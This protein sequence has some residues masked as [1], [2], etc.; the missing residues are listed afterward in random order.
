MNWVKS[1]PDS[2][3]DWTVE[4]RRPRIAVGQRLAGREHQLGVGHAEDLEHVVEL[5]LGAAVGHELLERPERVA[6]AAGGRARQH[7]HRRVGDLDPLL[8]RHPLASRRRSARATG[9]G[10]RSGGSGR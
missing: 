1:R 6:E 10:S 2:D 7:A 8:G 5:H 4:E 3:S 9:A